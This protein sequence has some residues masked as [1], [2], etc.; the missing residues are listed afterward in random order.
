MSSPPFQLARGKEGGGGGEARLAWIHLVRDSHPP[1]DPCS[2]S[3]VPFGNQREKKE[4]GKRKEGGRS[5]SI[6]FC[7]GIVADQAGEGTFT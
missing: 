4:R 5:Q 6:F 2:R 7:D 3:R 1:L